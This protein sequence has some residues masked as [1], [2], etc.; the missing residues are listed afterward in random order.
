MSRLRLSLARAAKLLRLLVLSP[1]ARTYLRRIR[2]SG[3]FDRSYYLRAHPGLRWV[4]RRFPERHYLLWGEAAG[5]QPN[6]D[7]SPGAYLA[8]NPDVAA[9][10][11]PAFDHYLS[12]GRTEGRLIR[13]LAVEPLPDC[14]TRPLRFDPDRPR[15]PVAIH[16]HI[17]YPDL[18]PEFAARLSSLEITADL[19]V[20]L[21]W[22]GPETTAL[23]D[24]IRAEFPGAFIQ[25]VPNRG[26]DI[27]PFVRLVNAGAF[28][29]YSAVCKLHTKKSPHRD[30]GDRWRRHLV[31]GVLPSTG[32]ADRLHRFLQD[33]EAAIWVADGQA[34]PLGEWWGSN[35]AKTEAVLRRLELN[36]SSTA[37]RFPAGSI[38][39]LKPLMIGMIR[40]LRLTDDM[41]EPE[42]GQI[43]GTLAHAVE[44]ALGPIAHAAGQQVREAST[45]PTGYRPAPAAPRYVSA[46]YLPQ[47]HPIPEN[48]RWWGRGFTEWRGVSAAVS[49]FPGHLQPMRPADLGYYDLR[50]TDIMADQAALARSAGIDAFCVYHYWFGGRRLL[51]TPLDKLLRCPD[52]DFPFYLCWANESWRRNWD[53]L[54]GEILAAQDYTP[55]FEAA[56]VQ[57]TLPYLRDA[58]YQR[59]DG[60]RPRVIIYR[61]SDMPAPEQN[62]ARMRRAWREAGIGE[63]EL[64]AVCFHIDG[65]SPVA[66]D[67][68]D[69]WIEMPP[70]AVVKPESYVFGGPSGNL[71]NDAAPAQGF[72]GLIYE[73][74]RVAD[75]ALSARYRSDLPDRTIAGIMPSWDNT[76]RRGPTAH[77]ARGA[78]PATFR[79][80]LTG[81]TDKALPGSYRNELFINAWNEWGEKA[82]MEPTEVFGRLNLDVLAEVTHRAEADALKAVSSRA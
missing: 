47:F 28:D 38:Y 76:A 9:A 26:R 71:L 61:P 11:R 45:L 78:N 41:F 8:L 48:D 2:R 12:L 31:D 67:L 37:A 63:V 55:G 51:Q 16:L 42:Q 59:P 60:R 39:W 1:T 14:A 68:F 69:F 49:A 23:S 53:G 6:K 74:S 73:Y 34:Y 33:R 65:A 3:A 77:I 54:S 30:D 13:K 17:Y 50:A 21:T 52:V 80:W 4:Y 81:L 43:D 79:R 72:N 40:G 5:L 75:H 70:H 44:R 57:S 18:W 35:R 19:Y 82:V 7:F 62:V 22:R 15:A 24:R 56:F 10:G 32:L 58:R 36:I 29:G 20:T 66:E 46:F 64:G 25:A 27:L